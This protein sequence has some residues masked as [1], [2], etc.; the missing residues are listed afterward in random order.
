MTHTHHVTATAALPGMLA[1]LRAADGERIVYVIPDE[2]SL[3]EV[4]LRVLRREA[5]ANCVDIA[6]VTAEPS[7]RSTADRVGISTFRTEQRAAKGRWRAIRPGPRSRLRPATPAEIALPPGGD[8]HSR[9]SPSGFRP[10]P[11]RRAFVRTPSQWW[12]T[13]GLLLGLGVLMSGLV[14]ALSAVIPAATVRVTPSSETLR[15]TV[16]LKA[17]PDAR[18]DTDE[19]IIPAQ[20]ISVQ[21]TGEARTKTTGR[22]QEPSGKAQGRVIFINRTSRDLNIPAGT[23]VSTATG[24]TVQFATVQ[25]ASVVPGGRVTV[26]VEAVLPGPDGNVRAGTITRVEGALSVSLAVANESG[27]AG[28]TTAP[29][30]FVMD[31]DK[32][33]LQEELFIQL[34][35]QAYERLLEREV[36]TFVAQN[37]VQFIALSPTFTPFVGEVSDDLFLSMS[38][39]AIALAVDQDAANEVALARLQAAM[40]SGTKMISDTIRFIPDAMATSNSDGSLNFGVTAQGTLLRSINTDEVRK[41]ALGLSPQEAQ[42]VL[43]QRFSLARRPE[44]N[45]GPDW[46]PYVVPVNLPELPWRI[47]VLVDWD[48]AARIALQ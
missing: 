15:L 35:Q 37:S 6:L 1:R 46:L 48:Q 13:L 29:V 40:P 36:G 5:A 43:A 39:Q 10:A 28:G 44:I 21:V 26:P 20:T 33:R 19:G 7:L 24:Y 23:R 41:A 9:R 2:V 27:F 25:P 38:V 14:Y 8:V 17:V 31:D 4:D 3:A 42:R 47:R 32:V 11:F 16:P 30:G 22:R 34:K 12:T 45:L 18:V